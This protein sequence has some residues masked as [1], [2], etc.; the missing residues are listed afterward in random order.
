MFNP[1]R[2]EA[3]RFFFDTWRKYKGQEPLS[4]LEKMA[5]EI[6]T[7]HPEYHRILHEPERF[8]EQDYSPEMSGVNPFLHMSMHLAIE[9]QL[10]VD[11]PRGVRAQFERM[12]QK[13][14]DRHAAL[15]AVMEC[16]AVMIWQAQRNNTAPNERTYL[17]CLEKQ[18][19]E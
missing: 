5:L 14:A 15:H 19:K 17:E 7:L 2:A 4:D 6:I 8:L 18:C 3:R 11:Q 9:E 16:L 1:S 12:L 10:S 13:T